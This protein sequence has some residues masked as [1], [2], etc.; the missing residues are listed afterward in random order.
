MRDSEGVSIGRL[1]KLDSRPAWPPIGCTIRRPVN[2]S[3][4]A[5]VL[6]G[7]TGPLL[8]IFL[9]AKSIGS[10]MVRGRRQR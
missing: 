6:M 9:S 5:V 10:R 4:K 3:I 2:E 8:S 1:F 7:F